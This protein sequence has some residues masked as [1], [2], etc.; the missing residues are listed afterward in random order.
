MRIVALTQKGV[1]KDENEDRI[2]VGKTI[3]AGGA[4]RCDNFTGVIAVADGVGGHKAGAVASHFV[5]NRVGELRNCTIDQFKAINQDLIAKSN[6]D[7]CLHNMATTLSGIYCDKSVINYFHVGNT[8]IYALQ[9]SGYLKQITEDDT[10]LNYLIKTGKLSQEDA[11]AFPNKNEITACFGAGNPELFNMKIA[12]MPD[13]RTLLLTS[14][15]VHEYASIDELED[16]FQNENDISVVCQK[17][18][19]RA[20]S[21]G[22]HD[23]ISVLIAHI[24]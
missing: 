9:G 5:A 17:I 11:V 8:R 13:V 3:L 21:N 24:E 20:V 7:E 15:G 19:E 16:I 4:F 14:D 1:N 10:T 6:S 2:I 18:A 12:N 23:D 22:S